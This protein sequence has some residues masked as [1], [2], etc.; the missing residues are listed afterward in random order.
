V[1]EDG[2]RIMN[3]ANQDVVRRYL[4]GAS[5]AESRDEL[6]Q[7]LFSD[8]QVFWERVA[9]AEDELIDDYAA[10]ALDA[11]ER[12]LCE[13]NFLCTAE[14]RAKLEF[15]RALGAYARQREV[16]RSGAWDLLRA[17]SSVP[18]WA[19]AAAAGLVLLLVPA[20]LWQFNSGGRAPAAITVSL[21]PGLLRDAGGE[22]ARV[23]LA[24]GC[25]VIHL[26]LAAADGPFAAYAATIYGVGGEA[27]WSQH[28]LTGASR[29]G[30]V[31]VRLTVPC[32]LLPEG[33]YWVRLSGLSPGKEPAT[34]DRYDFRVLR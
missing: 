18:R 10:G 2:V 5:D 13:A 30:A 9:V 20:I 28:K 33:D 23:R 12:G 11:D 32:D 3:A 6:E 1:D 15:A 26:D 29:D 14:R 17:P 31:L 22:T 19:V 4:L 34:L 25:Q 8:D 24:P 27:I 21:A 7:R 16:R